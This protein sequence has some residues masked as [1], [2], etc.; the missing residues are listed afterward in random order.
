MGHSDLTA[1]ERAVLTHLAQGHSVKTAA[2]LDGI[3]KYAAQELLRSVR[4][5]LGVTSSREAARLIANDPG[6]PK[7]CDNKSV[8]DGL[9][10]RRQSPGMIATGGVMI[11]GLLAGLATFVSGQA[12]TRSAVNH[13]E[14][15]KVMA[16]TP[17]NGK[18]IAAG[19]FTLSVTYDRPMQRGSMSFATGP[20]AAYPQCKGKPV[21][22][23]DGRTFSITCNAEAQRS[24]VVWFNHGR[25]MNFRD[26]AT[27][28][29][30]TPHRIV[31]S[32]HP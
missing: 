22:S 21:Q 25:F 19:R 10:R 26:A 2:E 8:M 32:V 17:A 24:Y 3:S 14:A 23:L 1:R 6:K 18:A 12:D 5:K 9:P 29:S 11:L 16:T 30:A 20:E 31:F 27:G 13:V 7:I 4:R 15:P 28:V